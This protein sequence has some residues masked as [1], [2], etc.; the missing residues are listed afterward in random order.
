MRRATWGWRLTSWRL[1]PILTAIMMLSPMRTFTRDLA[2]G[3]LSGDIHPS[4]LDQL[5]KLATNAAGIQV[6]FR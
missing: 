3:T 4:I 2:A 6:P 5:V 1:D